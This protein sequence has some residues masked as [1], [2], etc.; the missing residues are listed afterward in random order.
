MLKRILLCLP[1]LLGSAA[2]AAEPVRVVTTIE[3]F[4]ALAKAVGGDHV[5]VESLG[6]GYQDPHFVEPKP[7]FLVTL[8]KADLLVY[9]GLDL[10]VGWLPPLIANSRNARVQRGANGNLD[11]SSAIE[12]LDLAT[13]P[14]DRSQGDI[15]PMGNPHFW[16]PPVNALRV[17]KAIADRLGEIDPPHAAAYR[18]NLEKFGAELKAHA[19]GWSAQAAQ[20]KGTKVV[21][22]HK[23][24]TYVS[25]WLGLQE[26]GYVENKPGVPASPKHLAELVAAMQAQGVRLVLV[27][28]FYNRSVATLVADKAGGR[29]VVL[30]NDV[31]AFPEIRSYSDLVDGLLARLTA[32]VKP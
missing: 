12:V 15:H 22:Y 24:W 27:E 32:A 30:P 13:G 6:R 25:R 5:A 28:S 7:A 9:A 21:T 2:A 29:V 23:S 17:A 3:T 8:S 31:G 16:V 4:A 14:V 26:I 10:E 19:P 18:S 1:I 20:L 11:A